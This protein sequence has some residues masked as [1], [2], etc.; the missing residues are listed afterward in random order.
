METSSYK[1]KGGV[2]DDTAK[3]SEGLIDPEKLNQVVVM[4]ETEADKK[5]VSNSLL[6]DPSE[7]ES[8]IDDM[9]VVNKDQPSNKFSDYEQRCQPVQII[10]ICPDI[11]AFSVLHN[12][13]CADICTICQKC[14]FE[15]RKG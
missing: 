8:S 14:Q 7:E 11:C 12:R 10:C 13:H 1:D 5:K 6:K 2:D 15:V 9:E 4:K 3:H